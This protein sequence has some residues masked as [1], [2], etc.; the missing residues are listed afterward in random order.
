MLTATLAKLLSLTLL[1]G[2][3][4]SRPLQNGSAGAT[5]YAYVCEGAVTFS[6]VKTDHEAVVSFG[7]DVYRLQRRRSSIGERFVSPQA[8]LIVDGQSAVFVAD[9]RLGIRGCRAAH[10]Q[11]G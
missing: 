9:N 5:E 1:I 7:D 4:C 11:R 8:T 2:L 6:V 3:G 10:P